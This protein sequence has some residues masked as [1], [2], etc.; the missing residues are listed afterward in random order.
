MNVI[1]KKDTPHPPSYPTTRNTNKEGTM[2]KQRGKASPTYYWEH[3]TSWL[4][5]LSALLVHRRCI[6]PFVEVTLQSTQTIMSRITNGLAPG[7]SLNSKNVPRKVQ[8]NAEAMPAGTTATSTSTFREP[9]CRAMAAETDKTIAAIQTS[10][11]FWKRWR[12]QRPK[13]G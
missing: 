11:T 10:L 2:Q 5:W 9:I 7:Q 3:L 1:Q 12:H 8:P 13:G 4:W 6:Q